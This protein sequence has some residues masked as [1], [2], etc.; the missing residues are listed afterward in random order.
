MNLFLIRRIFIL[1]NTV[2][3]LGV[4]SVMRVYYYKIAIKFG[5]HSVLK[6][7]SRPLISSIYNGGPIESLNKSKYDYRHFYFF[8]KKLPK[9]KYFKKR[10]DNNFFL[11]NWFNGFIYTSN[12]PWFKVKDFDELAGDIKGVWELSRW[13]WVVRIAVDS[14][15]KKNEKLLLLNEKTSEWIRQ[16]PYLIGPNWKCGQEI[17]LRIIHFIFSLRLLGLDPS[18]I[19]KSQVE[20]IQIHLD[21]IL[22]TLSYA[23]GQKNNHWISE[24]TALFIGGVWLRNHNFSKK[25]PYYEIALKHLRFATN[26]LF[27]NDGSFAQSSFNYLR[28]TLTLLSL[29]KL[30]SEV[31][32]IHVEL[33]S[34]IEKSLLFFREFSAFDIKHSH[35]WGAN[36]GSDPLSLASENF[37]DSSIHLMFYDYVFFRIRPKVNNNEILTSIIKVYD[38][39]NSNQSINFIRDL[40]EKNKIKVYPLGG[41]TFFRNESYQILIR[42]PNFNFKP[43]QDDVG[44]IDVICKDG[45]LIVDAGTFSYFLEKKKFEYFQGV[46]SHNT[47]YREN[48]NFNMGKLSRF[49]FHSWAKGSWTKIN[50]CN[51]AFNFKNIHND[52]FMRKFDFK[53]NSLKI[54]DKVTSDRSIKIISGL[55]FSIY[56]DIPIS[57]RSSHLDLSDKIKFYSD[58]SY[59]LCKGNISKCYGDSQEVL[60]AKI[61]IVNGENAFEVMFHD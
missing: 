33:D 24:I 19:D 54:V 28:H 5:I 8:N 50:K 41:L 31:E 12:K 27:N 61:H 51:F 42:L 29:I 60:R 59:D 30:E 13:Y 58:T 17:S 4:Y 44:H 56:K 37:L 57:K 20:F 1:I 26:E 34:K 53:K 2:L 23:R 9:T 52:I 7:K 48:D 15:I 38:R 3:K 36:D 47:I 32:E 11:T 25:K 46:Q 10:N 43:S 49:I 45:P 40:P 39:C 16:N 18:K 55:N 6:L 22:P 35:N 21:R 14:S